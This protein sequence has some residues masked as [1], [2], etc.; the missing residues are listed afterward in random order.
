MTEDINSARLILIVRVIISREYVF[1][2]HL[3]HLSRHM[4]RVLPGRPLLRPQEWVFISIEIVI[5]LPITLHYRLVRL[6]N[7][8]ICSTTE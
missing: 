7:I 6:L 8:I 5:H 4:V 3:G 2:V 1:L